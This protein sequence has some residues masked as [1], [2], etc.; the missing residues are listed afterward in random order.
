MSLKCMQN[1]PALTVGVNG[2]GNGDVR[3]LDRVSNGGSPGP[4]QFREYAPKGIFWEI[5]VDDRPFCRDACFQ[6]ANVQSEAVSSC[7]V[8]VMYKICGWE[9]EEKRVGSKF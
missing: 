5:F 1:T 2:D 8:T 9:D 7:T 3:N 6:H 4:S